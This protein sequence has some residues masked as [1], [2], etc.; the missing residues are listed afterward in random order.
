[1]YS[2][3]LASICRHGTSRASWSALRFLSSRTLRTRLPKLPL[4]IHNL[5]LG[6]VAETLGW[7]FFTLPPFFRKVLS[8]PE[9]EKRYRRA[10][11]VLALAIGISDSGSPRGSS[12]PTRLRCRGVL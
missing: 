6:E 8:A 1:M 4:A 3:T 2:L 12:Q 7:S 10:T 11:F 5:F 9:P